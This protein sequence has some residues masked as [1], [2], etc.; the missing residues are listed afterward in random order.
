MHATGQVAALTPEVTL[1]PDRW[2]HGLNHF[3]PSAVA[4]QDARPVSPAFDP[5]RDACARTYRYHL[6]LS[7]VRQPLWE[8][9]AWVVRQALDAAR[10]AEALALLPG[11]RD[12]ASFAGRPARGGSVRTLCR[13][14][15]LT[16]GPADW[17]LEFC[18]NAFLPHQ[19]RRT[20]GLL[21]EVGRGRVLPRRLSELL[22]QPRPGAAGPAAPPQGLHLAGVRYRLA[23]LIDWNE[24]HEDP[25]HP[26]R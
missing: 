9:R 6:R 7:P 23:E 11:T 3:L 13:A 20:V 4:V 1:P 19:I 12:F 21:V 2:L 25:C 15:L 8:P 18:A 14:R 26:R 10:M 16:P 5:R 24:D 22:A 17:R